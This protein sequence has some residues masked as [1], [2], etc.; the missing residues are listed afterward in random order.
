MASI[1]TLAQE[2]YDKAKCDSTFAVSL[3][4]AY[5]NALLGVVGGD[6]QVD[7]FSGTKNGAS[8]QGRVGISLEERR[9]AMKAAITGLDQGIRPSNRGLLRFN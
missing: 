9:V 6:S 8:Y 5:S 7:I 2:L 3:R 1:I 4:E